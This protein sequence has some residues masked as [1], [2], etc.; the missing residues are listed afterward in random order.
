[1]PDVPIQVQ[2][3]G[4]KELILAGGKDGD[5]QYKRGFVFSTSGVQKRAKFN[6]DLPALIEK[7]KKEAAEFAKKQAAEE[8][9]AG[10]GKVTEPLPDG[11]VGSKAELCE[12][13]AITPEELKGYWK[14]EGRP[15][16][17]KHKN[18]WAHDV[19][20]WSEFIHKAD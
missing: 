10:T 19:A 1:M 15:K 12:A 7:Q 17:V 4:F 5:V 9:K 16:A 6:P 11:L 3:D 14:M 20:A 13:L 2:K 18:K 8:K